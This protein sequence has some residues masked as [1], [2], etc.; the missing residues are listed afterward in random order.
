MIV[1]WLLYACALI[2]S[3]ATAW[4]TIRAYRT[5]QEVDAE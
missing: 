5:T 2:I 1:E 3:L 4:T